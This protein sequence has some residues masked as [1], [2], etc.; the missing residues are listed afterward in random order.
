MVVTLIAMSM[1]EEIKT[2]TYEVGVN[3]EPGWKVLAGGTNLEIE[4]NGSEIELTILQ[5]GNKETRPYISVWV[6]GE[7]GW[8]IETPNEMPMISPGGSAP[9]ILNITPSNNSQYGNPVELYVKVREGDASA[10]SEVTLPLRVAEINDFKMTS[11][12]PWQISKDGGKSLVILEN[13]GNSPTTIN[14]EILSVPEGWRTSGNNIIVISP[15]QKIGMPLEII[16]S[17]NWTG[18]VKTIRILAQDP[19]GNQKEI[20]IETKYEENSWSSSPMITSLIGD[21]AILNIHGTTFDSVIVDEDGNSLDWT[22]EGWR[23]PALKSGFGNLTINQN[24]S[25]T[26]LMEVFQPISKNVSCQISGE[27]SNI[28]S[29]CSIEDGN[30]SF[31]YVVLLIDDRGYSLD[32]YYGTS[33]MNSEEVV[34]NLS[35]DEWDPSPGMRKLTIKIFDSYGKELASAEKYFE[36]RKNNWNIGL[37]SVDLS[38]TGENQIIEITAE[39]FG[40][41]QLIDADCKITLSSSGYESTQKIDMS[42]RSILTPKPK[43]DRPLEIADGEEIVIEIGCL[44]PWDI[45]SNPG[46]N[47]IR[48]VLTGGEVGEEEIDIIESIM[49]AVVVILISASLAWISKNRREMKEFEEMARQKIQSKIESEKKQE[50]T[51]KNEIIED[52]E[53][54]SKNIR[55]DEDIRIEEIPETELKIDDGVEE[56]V[57]DDFERRLRPVSYTHLTL[58]TKA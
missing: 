26:Y 48:K 56:E 18:E 37:T 38:G 28:Q 33:G 43:F 21:N 32:S 50:N 15:G 17:E 54:N 3:H 36:I 4:N 13:T 22:E 12:G 47:E 19:Q 53:V 27:F 55:N 16:P 51:N 58:P 20:L 46:D 11:H 49:A 34:I 2:F 44:F 14:L 57:L 45:D 41:G 25:L 1:D 6:V 39:R 23:F 7:S 35:S 8:N 24:S 31:D 29:T 40:H 5:M 30:F 10:V 52:N 9:L 42:T